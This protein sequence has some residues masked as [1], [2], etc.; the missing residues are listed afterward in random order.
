MDKRKKIC[1]RSISIY[2]S[3]QSLEDTT[4]SEIYKTING[5]NIYIGVA[6]CEVTKTATISIMEALKKT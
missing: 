3:M 2:Y 4:M 5:Y 6:W 1:C